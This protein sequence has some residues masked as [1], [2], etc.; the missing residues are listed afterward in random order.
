MANIE[1]LIPKAYTSEEAKKYGRLGGL[2]SAEKKRQ[3]KTFRELAQVALNT[4]IDHKGEKIT[5]KDAI[6]LKAIQQAMKG[7]T[8][9]REWLTKILGEDI[10]KHEILSANLNVQKVYVTKE[11]ELNVEKHIEEF[12]DG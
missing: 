11:D 7:D 10:I 4:E 6:L 3:L 1:N 9:A 12:I 8:K 5:A 2:K